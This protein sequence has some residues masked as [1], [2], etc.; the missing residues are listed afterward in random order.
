MSK[1]LKSSFKNKEG[2]AVLELLIQNNILTAL[3][4][5]LKTAWPTKI[6]MPFLS[7][8]IFFFNKMHNSFFRK[9]LIILR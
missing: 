7:S 4:Y 1:E 2:Q 6:S 8:L 5:N 3:I 9:L